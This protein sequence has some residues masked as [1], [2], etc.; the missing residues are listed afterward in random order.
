MLQEWL[1]GCFRNYCSD[2]AGIGVRMEQEYTPS[3]IEKKF[4]LSMSRKKV[5]KVK[6]QFGHLPSAILLIAVS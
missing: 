1:S 6:E 5:K 4:I 2:V 3:L